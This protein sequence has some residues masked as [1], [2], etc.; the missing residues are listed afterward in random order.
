[1]DVA[2]AISVEASRRIHNLELDVLNAETV[3]IVFAVWWRRTLCLYVPLQF[4]ITF[5]Q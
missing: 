2:S 4:Y 3:Y 5:L 1:L